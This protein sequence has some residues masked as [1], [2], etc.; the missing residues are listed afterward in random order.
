MSSGSSSSSS[1]ATNHESATVPPDGTRIVCLRNCGMKPAPT[2]W[3]VCASTVCSLPERNQRDG[4]YGR[5][6]AGQR[7]RRNRWKERWAAGESV[8]GRG[9][10]R[11]KS[12]LAKRTRTR[13]AR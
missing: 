6:S 3:A 11:R 1:T 9:S 10:W 4:L 2:L 7:E 12:T 13:V 5:E 8:G